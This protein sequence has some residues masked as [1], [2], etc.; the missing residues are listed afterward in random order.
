MSAEERLLDAF[1]ELGITIR[2]TEA[3]GR[4]DALVLDPDGIA[5]GIEV[6]QRSLVTEDV[7]SRLVAEVA[8]NGIAVVVVADRVTAAARRILTANGCGFLDLRGRLALRAGGFVIDAEVEPVRKRTSRKSAL[9]GAAGLEVAIALLMEPKRTVVVRELAREIG[10]SPSTVSETLAALRHDD[11]VDEANTVVG[12]GLFWQVAD[13]WVVKRIPLARPPVPD[14]PGLAQPLRLGNDLLD[15]AP[16]WALTDS[17]AAAVYGA[18]VAFRAG[19]VQDFF[20]PDEVVARR[21]VTLL[22]SAEHPS[23]ARATVRV[24]PV[25]AVVRRRVRVSTGGNPWP[26]AQPL[27][28]AL[29]LAQ[30]LGR[31]REILD[32]WNPTG[33]WIRVW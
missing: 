1:A 7:A 15:D 13:R 19:Q 6:K 10:R 18:P 3:T 33:G 11:L 26:L 25:P 14:D 30:D 21:A 4:G 2:A 17:A 22:G 20:V 8:P 24:A 31:G 29:D 9:G 16:G 5:V 27:F 28:V 32:Q 23:Q 12:T